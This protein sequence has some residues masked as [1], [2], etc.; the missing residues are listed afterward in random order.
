MCSDS[1]YS[2]SKISLEWLKRIFHPE[3][4]ERANKK[5]W[6]PISDGFETHETV[7]VLEFCFENNIILCYLPSHT[8]YKL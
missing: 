2:D 1:R 3:T 6:V 8:P 5:P 4:Q 7:E